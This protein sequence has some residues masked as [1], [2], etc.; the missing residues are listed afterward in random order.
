MLDLAVFLL[1]VLHLKTPDLPHLRLICS[2]PKRIDYIRNKDGLWHQTVSVFTSDFASSECHESL[3]RVFLA[4]SQDGTCRLRTCVMS[5]NLC[6][7]S[8]CLA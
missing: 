5:H 2:H 1:P 4:T 7:M 8:L 6:K 3:F